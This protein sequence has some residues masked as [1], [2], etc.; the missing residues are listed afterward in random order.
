MN[1]PIGTRFGKL[2]I[3]RE[4]PLVHLSNGAVQRIFLCRCD[5]GNEVEVRL[6]HL[7][8]SAKDNCGCARK[9]KHGLYNSPEYRV[10]QQMKDRCSNKNSKWYP[11]YGGRGIRVCKEWLNDFLQFYSDMGEKPCKGF[12]IDRIDNNGTY[13]K[14]NCR[15]WM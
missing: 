11:S 7:R 14:E 8:H 13:C 15:C 2:V 4:L 1:V 5:C 6:L 9:V 12:T 10:W 3:L